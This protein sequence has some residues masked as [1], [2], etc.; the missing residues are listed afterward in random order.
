MPTLEIALSENRY[1]QLAW[2]AQDRQTLILVSQAIEAFLHA[3]DREARYAR[4]AR[5]G[6]AWR[7]LQAKPD[8]RL[9]ERLDDLRLD[10]IYH[11]EA[12]ENSPLT[13]DQVKDA[14]EELD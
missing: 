5:K 13:R 1:E 8:P 4:L 2:L 10:L 9:Q 6:A 12:L 11:S 14:I 3:Q 7:A